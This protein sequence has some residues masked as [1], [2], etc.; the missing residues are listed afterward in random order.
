M[1]QFVINIVFIFSYLNLI[2]FLVRLNCTTKRRRTCLIWSRRGE[3]DKKG[4]VV[5]GFGQIIH[6]SLLLHSREDMRNSFNFLLIALICMDSCYLVGAVVEAFRRSFL[7]TTDLHKILFPYFLFPGLN[8]AM[9][10]SVFMT[11][12]RMLVT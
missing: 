2:C 3:R 12:S 4:I 8:I 7:L 11:V 9:T 6:P 5:R 10:A 1:L